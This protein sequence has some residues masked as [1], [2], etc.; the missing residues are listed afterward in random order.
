MEVNSDKLGIMIQKIS[1]YVNQRM[2]ENSSPMKK[3]WR[4]WH[5]QGMGNGQTGKTAEDGMSVLQ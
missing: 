4:G 3:S 2:G 5:L 1:G